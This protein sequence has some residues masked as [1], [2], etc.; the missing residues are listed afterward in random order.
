MSALKF[1]GMPPSEV[2]RPPPFLKKDTMK[3]Y[4]RGGVKFRGTSL[5]LIEKKKIVEY[6]FFSKKNQKIGK[7]KISKKKEFFFFF[8]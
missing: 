2:T 6:I 8:F 1:A 4:G 3:W 7:K 5:K